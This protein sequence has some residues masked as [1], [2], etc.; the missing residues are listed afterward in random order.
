MRKV[1]AALALACALLPGTGAAEGFLYINYS[2]DIRYSANGSDARIALL[3]EQAGYAFGHDLGQLEPCA[4]GASDC[5]AFDFMAIATPP[6][7]AGPGD[8]F[9]RGTF[10]FEVEG[11]AEISVL[12]VRK[13]V[14]RIAV[15]KNGQLSNRFYFSPSHGV[16][17]IGVINFGNRHIPESMFL[18]ASDRGALHP[19]S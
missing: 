6:S 18:L 19:G 12:G 10:E 11:R 8:R 7:E 13:E 16:V 9:S 14:L 5:L 4:P 17:A 1:L 2:P 3:P 15:R